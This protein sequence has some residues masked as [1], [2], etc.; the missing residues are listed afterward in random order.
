MAGLTASAGAAN[1]LFNG[2]FELGNVGFTTDFNFSAGSIV[3]AQTYDTVSNPAEVH[4]AAAS[5]DDR[6]PGNGGLML[7]VNGSTSGSTVLWS[8][9]IDVT[10]QTDYD[11][12]LW[13]SSWFSPGTL[14]LF[15]NDE[16]VGVPFITPGVNAVWEETTRAW[17]SDAATTAVIEL[18]NSSTSFSGNDFA[19]DDLSFSAVVSGLP[20]DYDDSGQ[21]EQGDLNFVLNNW[22]LQ[23][24]F[25]PNGD[26][27][28]TSIVDQEELNRVLNN[29]GDTNAT[30][31]FSGFANV[32]EPVVG[33]G[34][35]LCGAMSLRRRSVD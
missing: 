18:V 22:G 24:P 35:A 28:I 12:R 29:W 19:I 10:P 5:Y 7:A 14:E 32:P 23:A 33:L 2:D 31:G 9:T 30:P 11:F 1:L 15:I 3:P 25:E 8:Q 13:T 26:P 34:L 4:F 21:V 20:G 17:S 6:T 16:P 27:F